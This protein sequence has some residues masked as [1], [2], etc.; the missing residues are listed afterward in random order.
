MIQEYV[1]QGSTMEMDKLLER[2][3]SLDFVSFL[4]TA[5]ACWAVCLYLFPVIIIIRLATTLVHFGRWNPVL[6]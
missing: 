2:F 3:V 4:D 5:L 1:S 6:L